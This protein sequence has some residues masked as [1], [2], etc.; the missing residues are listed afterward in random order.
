MG[1]PPEPAGWDQDRHRPV[2]RDPKSVERLP[3]RHPRCLVLQP[4]SR[5]SEPLEG[6]QTAKIAA[7]AFYSGTLINPTGRTSYGTDPHVS[8][9]ILSLWHTLSRSIHPLWIRAC[10]GWSKPRSRWEG[11]T[12]TKDVPG[13]EIWSYRLC[14]ISDRAGFR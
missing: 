2:T 3:M 13:R 1:G 6:R 14:R 11:E 8:R 12:S 10:C 9:P 5:V 4:R 7:Y